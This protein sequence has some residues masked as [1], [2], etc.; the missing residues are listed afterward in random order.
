MDTRIGTRTFKWGARRLLLLVLAGIATL[1]II[2]VAAPLVAWWHAD[3][4]N[5]ERLKV[6]ET[7]GILRCHADNVSPWREEE[8]NVDVA[9]TTH[10]IGWGGRASTSVG[11]Y[12]SLNDASAANALSA[13]TVCAQSSGWVLTKL[14][15]VDL[16]GTKS[17][18]GGWTA[19]LRIFLVKQT[20]IT[21]QPLIEVLLTTEP[22]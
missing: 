21:D 14:P 2:I 6:L 11:R 16:I 3:S 10:G 17:F 4:V 20:P 12:F 7:D 1:T 15:G 22:V 9:G 13:F 19:L 18:P 8:R 5:A